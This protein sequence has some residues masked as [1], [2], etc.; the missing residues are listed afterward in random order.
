M[1]KLFVLLLAVA[2][3]SI[4]Y[5]QYDV[6]SVKSDLDKNEVK[7]HI[8]FLASDELKGRDTPSEGLDKAAEYISNHL[9]K[10]GVK[11]FPEYNNYFQSVKL[12]ET[13]APTSINITIDDKIR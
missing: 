11:P 3:I 2:S 12:K 13:T 10:Y 5:S 1:K 9:K 4:S 8:Y 7:S 6:E